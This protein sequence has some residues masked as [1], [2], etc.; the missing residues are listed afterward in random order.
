[1][2]LN[3]ALLCMPLTAYRT[4]TGINILVGGGGAWF[5]DAL[6]KRK[7]GA[8]LFMDAWWLCVFHPPN[9]C[10]PYH[11]VSQSFI[12]C[13]EL[14]HWEILWML[15]KTIKDNITMYIKIKLSNMTHVDS[16]HDVIK[17]QVAGHCDS[18]CQTS[19]LII[20]CP[21]KAQRDF[22]SQL[23]H[24]V[25]IMQDTLLIWYLASPP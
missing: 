8:H 22:F 13:Q 25:Y 15:C 3:S 7:K 16:V 12:Y 24:N 21:H 20:R 4:S 17:R 9:C 10:P 6:T 2:V 1:M 23:I 19:T 18:P 5:R 14:V 11:S